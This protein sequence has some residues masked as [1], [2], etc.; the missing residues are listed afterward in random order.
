MKKEGSHLVF[1]SREELKWH[2]HKLL[3]KG[4]VS[5][6][7][8]MERVVDEEIYPT[9]KDLNEWLKNTDYRVK[10]S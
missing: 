6:Q 8:Y 7:F 5:A 1:D 2:F 4:D 9:I 3:C 10:E